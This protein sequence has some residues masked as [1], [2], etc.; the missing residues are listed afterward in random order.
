MDASLKQRL[1]GAAV[2]IALAVIFLPML[3]KGPLPDNGAANISMKIPAEPKAA[4]GMATQDLPLMAP[5]AAP[6]T[7]VSGMPNAEQ[8][9]APTATPVPAPEQAAAVPLPAVAAG[10][11]AVSFG[12]YANVADADK[13]IA[14]LHAAGLPGYHEAVSLGSKQA[15]RVRI[16]PFA[17]RALAESARLRATQVRNDVETKV[18]V[19]DAAPSAEPSA[20][21]AFSTTVTT[22][23]NQAAVKAQAPPAAKLEVPAAP[24]PA[25]KLETPAAA[26]PATK[27]ATKPE[28]SKPAPSTSASKPAASETPKAEPPVSKPANPAGT[29]FVVQM[30]AFASATDATA[31]RDTLRKAGFNAFTDTVPSANGS[32]TRVR[33]GPVI[34]RAEAEALK[35]KLEHAGKAG[36]MIRPHP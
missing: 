11:Y 7:G 14:A 6:A 23:R 13:V 9:S 20:A 5:A 33:V 17:D 31:L 4:E 15:Q 12:N 28:P 35:S 16:G 27:P 30:G 29:G 26:K 18:V 2:L 19:L 25:S 10:D 22:D 21:P 34:N 1:V 8:N 3:V 36:G 24:K 32:L